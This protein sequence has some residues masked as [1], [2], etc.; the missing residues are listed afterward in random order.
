MNI[1]VWN[2]LVCKN[3]SIKKVFLTLTIISFSGLSAMFPIGETRT[4][5]PTS[6]FDFNS[7]QR[8]VDSWVSRPTFQTNDLSFFDD[9]KKGE[10]IRDFKPGLG[11]LTV[12]V[13]KKVDD[14]TGVIATTNINPAGKI[15]GS[16]TVNKKTGGT[17]NLI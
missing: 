5:E 10:T 13:I 9:M 17:C 16:G 11:D 8:G 15:T 3:I 4:W 2:T 6:N 7:D 1:Q 14:N 12:T